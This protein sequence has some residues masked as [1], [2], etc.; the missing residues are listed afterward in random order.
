MFSI[1]DPEYGYLNGLIYINEIYSGSR[2]NLIVALAFALPA[3]ANLIMAPFFGRCG[4]RYGYWPILFFCLASMAVSVGLQAISKDAVQLL[5]LRTLLGLS[6]AGILPSAYAIIGN[7]VP[8][9]RKG[10][11]YGIAGSMFALGN[12]L[13]PMAGGIIAAIVNIR[14]V[15]WVTA[16]I[17]AMIDILAVSTVR[18]NIKARSSS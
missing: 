18:R 15:F 11:A 3:A 1:W 6:A 5:I 13:G 12:F 4:D 16:V 10:H 17:L 2:F 9:T 8:D 7:L 14:M